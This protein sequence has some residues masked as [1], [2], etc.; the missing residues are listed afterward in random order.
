MKKVYKMHNV[1]SNTKCVQA[2]KADG[3]QAD[4]M[5]AP[6]LLEYIETPLF[7]MNSK[8]DSWQLSNEADSKIETDEVL[9]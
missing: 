8:Y 1:Q 3:A 6:I 7:I 4:C 9:K 5:F 2:K